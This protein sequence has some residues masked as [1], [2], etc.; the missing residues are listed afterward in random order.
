MAHQTSG[1]TRGT[2]QM[3]S[4]M[5]CVLYMLL[6]F[7]L[8]RRNLARRA[9]RTGT[10]NPNTPRSSRLR[11][12]HTEVRA[13]RSRMRARLSSLIQILPFRRAWSITYM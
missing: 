9:L 13:F 11:Y 3:K 2:R 1:Q 12:G 10:S 8:R 6:A 5:R 7:S 4:S